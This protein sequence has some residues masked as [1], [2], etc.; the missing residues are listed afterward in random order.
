MQPFPPTT[1]PTDHTSVPAPPLAGLWDR[2]PPDRQ[3]RLIV[4]I[5]KMLQRQMNP[6]PREAIHEH[7]GVERDRARI[8]AQ[9]Q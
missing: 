5:S 3:Q 7:D 4:A 1:C 6:T 8:H 2:L 9:D